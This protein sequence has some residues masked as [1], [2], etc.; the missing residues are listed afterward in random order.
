[1]RDAKQ[2]LDM[3]DANPVLEFNITQELVDSVR[4]IR[5]KINELA[6]KLGI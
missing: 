4:L 6:T 1:M 2:M 5:P 3:K